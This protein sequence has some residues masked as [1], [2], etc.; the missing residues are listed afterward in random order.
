MTSGNK[1]IVSQKHFC[2]QCGS[3][4]SVDDKFCG[5]CGSPVKP[6]SS[7]FVSQTNTVVASAAQNTA[8]TRKALSDSIETVAG[9][10]L[11][12]RKKGMFGIEMFH[13]IVTSTRIIFATFTNDMAKQ[14]AKEAGQTGFFSGIAGAATVGYT[15]YKKYLSMDPEAALKENP[16]NFAVPR[17]NLRKVRLEIGSRHRDPKTKRETWDESKLEFETTGEK[18]SFKAPHQMHDQAQEVLRKGGLV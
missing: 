16:Q 11:V 9:A 2:T 13:M 12:T 4:L 7:A 14:A 1:D 10:V 5:V 6:S 15:Y 8:E 18:Y 17:S 3:P